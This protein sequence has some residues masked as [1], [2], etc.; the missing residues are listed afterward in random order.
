M[1]AFKNQIF[2]PFGPMET[3]ARWFSTHPSTEQRVHRLR[4]MA[5]RP[6]IQPPRQRWLASED[7]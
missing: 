7:W 6:A 3:V 1:T 5:K 2:N 4:A